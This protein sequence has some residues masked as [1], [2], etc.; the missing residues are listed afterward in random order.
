MDN[1]AGE[2][3]VFV[4]VVESGSFSEAARLLHMTP[5]TVSKLVARIE[6]RLGVRLVERSTR[7]LTLTNEGQFYYDRSVEL[8]GQIEDAEQQLAQGGAEPEG[9]VRVNSSVSFGS[10]GIE[11]LLPAFWQAY[12]KVIVDLTLSDDV[13]D[14][15]LERADLAFRVGA[16][17]DSNLMARKIGTTRRRIV[18]SP[19]YLAQRGTPT[20]PA[21]LLD[22]NCLGFNFRRSNPV[23]PMRES[24]RIVERMVSGTLIANNA[25][26]LRRMALFDVGL[27]RVADY[28]L[29]DHIARGEL[30][31]VLPDSALSED[32]E[33][34]AVFKGATHMPARTRV[35]LDFFV[36]RLQA[37]LQGK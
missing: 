17:P 23:W 21:E 11:P 1:R 30:I 12:P 32:D 16:L 8:L 27:I 26:T 9:V 29:R 34:H 14:L 36:P 10:A 7:Q 28:H 19:V 24:G 13:V 35:F 3:S 6:A 2:M 15:Y 4:R 37:F 22:H 5:S 31:E 18:G 20:T 33:I 25:D